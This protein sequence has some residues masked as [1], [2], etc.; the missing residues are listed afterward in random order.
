MSEREERKLEQLRERRAEIELEHE[1]TIQR[2]ERLQDQIEALEDR[3]IGLTADRTR[4]VE[5]LAKNAELRESRTVQLAGID[6]EKQIVEQNV[7]SASLSV[8]D[9][10]NR[11][12]EEERNIEGLRQRQFETV[13]REARI[14]NEA[15]SRKD[16]ATRL[17]AQIDRLGK[18][19]SRGAL[20]DDSSRTTAD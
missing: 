2:V 14:R 16:T 6:D 11:R 3:K 7:S 15:V 8:A 9:C 17:S 20:A 1:K 10:A 4:G 19:R 18:G 12:N 5:E 13:G